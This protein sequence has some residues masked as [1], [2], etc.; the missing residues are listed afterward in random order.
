MTRIDELKSKI[1]ESKQRMTAINSKVETEKRVKNETERTD[2]DNLINEV[3]SLEKE[4]ADVESVERIKIE[5][6]SIIT[7]EQ[8]EKTR[9]YNAVKAINEFSQNRLSGLELE[10]HQEASRTHQEASGLLIPNELIYAPKRTELYSNSTG[11]IGQTVQGLDIVAPVSLIDKM[12]ITQY[13]DL[14]TVHKLN[15]AKGLDAEQKDE[16][17]AFSE[18]S[19]TKSTDSLEPKAFG[20]AINV[21]KENLSVASMLQEMIVDADVTINAQVFKSI[22]D[23]ILS[24]S[25]L[26]YTSCASGDTATALTSKKVNALKGSVL[27]PIFR[28]PGYV[29]GSELYSELEET[30][31]GSTLHTIIENGKIKGYNAY[32]VMSLL[33]V[34]STNKYDL[35]YGDWSRAYV[36]WFGGAL[37]V[38]VN[39]YTND[40]KRQIRLTFNRLADTSFNPYVFKT[41]RNA[42]LA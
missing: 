21:S 3:R 14:K 8:K 35:I 13:N 12:G 39:P 41:I 6:P 5:A 36:G 17:S 26:C 2:F 33:S 4:L 42:K 10:M 18:K 30:V 9:K 1:A 7:S 16:D 40:L 28:N 37:E 29:M 25:G 31:A 22:L 32:D 11:L 34:H 38:L 15:Y 20:H 27:S 24:N 23:G 19:Y